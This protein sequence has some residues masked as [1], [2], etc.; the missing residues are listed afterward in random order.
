MPAKGS[1]LRLWTERLGI[2]ADP[3]FRDVLTHLVENSIRHGATVRSI[4]ASW[5][6]SEEELELIIED[7]GRGIPVDKKESVFEYD[8]GQHAGLGLFICRQILGVTGIT[9]FETGIEGRGARFVIRIPVGNWRI[10]GTGED[11]PAVPLPSTAGPLPG[12]DKEVW[13]LLSAEFPVADALWIDYHETKGDPRT[14]RI[15]AVFT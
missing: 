5:H 15:F 11:A 10:E 9:I 2:Y 13:E 1:S 3:L 8:S 7:D 14:D 6:Q 12:P 4:I